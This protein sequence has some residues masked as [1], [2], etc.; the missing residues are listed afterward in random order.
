M[1]THHA[2]HKKNIRKDEPDHVDQIV[3]Y[4]VRRMDDLVDRDDNKDRDRQKRQHNRCEAAGAQCSFFSD[5]DGRN[6]LVRTDL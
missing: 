5:I 2:G 3:R 6:E 4:D 1:V